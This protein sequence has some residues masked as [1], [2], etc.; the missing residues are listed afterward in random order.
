MMMNLTKWDL[1]W[2]AEMA[3]AGASPEWRLTPY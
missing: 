2:G 1:V 3:G